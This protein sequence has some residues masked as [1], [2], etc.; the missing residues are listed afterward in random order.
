M[1]MYGETVMEHFTNPRDEDEIEDRGRR[2]G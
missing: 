1:A 2:P